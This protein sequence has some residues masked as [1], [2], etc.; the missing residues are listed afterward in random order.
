MLSELESSK[1][2]SS[3][4]PL[5]SR[6]PSGPIAQ[7]EAR[8]ANANENQTTVFISFDSFLTAEVGGSSGGGRVGCGFFSGR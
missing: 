8:T 4:V 5:Q 1:E 3:H 7:P 2:A 6:G